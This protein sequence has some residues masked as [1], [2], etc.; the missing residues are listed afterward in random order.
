MAI[1]HYVPR[2]YLK[3]FSIPEKEGFVCAYERNKNPFTTNIK[4]IASERNFYN[5]TNKFTMEE[6]DSV[7]KMFSQIEGDASSI[8]NKIINQDNFNISENEKIRLAFFIAFLAVR[9]LSHRLK[10][11]NLEIE[12]RKKLL[13][14]Y[15]QNED[16]FKKMIRKKEPQKSDSEIEDLRKTILNFDKHFILKMKDGE[17]YFLKNSLLMAP[18]LANVILQKNWHIIKSSGSRVFIT[19]DNPV[20][21]IPPKQPHPY[22]GGGFAFSSI[23]T[24]LTP[25]KCLLL[26]N[27]KGGD[28]IIEV[29]RDVVDSTNYYIMFYAHK[30]IF[31]NYRSKDIQ[32]LFNQTKT[33]V[34][35]KVIVG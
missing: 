4:N 19:S 16:W 26:K 22:G 5:F 17:A 20:T 23:V 29:K 7:E 10:Q 32:N 28:G 30:F 35:E 11:Q 8:I 9:N 27:E 34:S 2:F 21:L 25:E 33:G 24:P 31:S 6:D 14:I 3:S 12:M 18:D 13:K 1:H 15:A